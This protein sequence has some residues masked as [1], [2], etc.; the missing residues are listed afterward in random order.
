[1]AVDPPTFSAK[2]RR[3]Q[4]WWRWG[5]GIGL[6]ITLVW[7]VGPT[8]IL[9]TFRRVSVGWFLVITVLALL[10]LC[11]GALN[12][13][14]LLRRL[15]PI[16]LHVFLSVYVVSWAT[17]L[18]LPGQL[19]DVSQVLLL[20]QHGV[21]IRSSGAAYV[22]DKTLSLGW[23]GLVASYGIGRY[24]LFVQG[25]QLVIPPVLGGIAGVM[26]VLTVK[27]LSASSASAIPQLGGLL[28]QVQTF[29]S[30]PGTVMLNLTVTMLKWLLMAFFYWGAFHAFDASLPFEAAAVIPVMSSFVGY[31][32]VTVGGAGTMEWTSVAIFSQV[33]IAD[34]TVLSVHL[35]LRGILL[36]A[37]LL[38]LL[39]ARLGNDRKDVGVRYDE[40]LA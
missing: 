36:F 15:E 11:L 5:V 39:I 28:T 24:L 26:G 34:V 38:I 9:D 7:I 31:I 29:Q 8:A 40:R 1:M 30:Y 21:S 33:G 10:W 3:W 12:V 19:G 17:S 32:P 27:R 13:W 35:F 6:L 37:A 18:L 14:F 16:R 2:F 23:L 20:R 22:V 25:W 4:K